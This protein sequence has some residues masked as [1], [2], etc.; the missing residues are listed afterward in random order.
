MSVF[1]KAQ[2]YPS[3]I[4]VIEEQINKKIFTS[5]KLES[6]NVPLVFPKKLFK[7]IN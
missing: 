3:G 2:S 7:L 6:E 4:S 5:K 1:P